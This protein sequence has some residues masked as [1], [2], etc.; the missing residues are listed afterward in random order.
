MHVLS[1]S[2]GN[3]NIHLGVD[4]CRA[5]W[6]V[7]AT[8]PTF[9]MA[10]TLIYTGYKFFKKRK[11]RNPDGPF[12]GGSPLWPAL[13]MTMLAFLVASLV[14]LSLL[15]RRPTRNDVELLRWCHIS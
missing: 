9:P 14:R 4:A 13:G 7:G 2:A 12:F 10:L 1:I 15:T 5:A 8:D 6:Q 11:N 3:Y